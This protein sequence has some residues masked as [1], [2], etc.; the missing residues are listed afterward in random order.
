MSEGLIHE[1]PLADYFEAVGFGEAAADWGVEDSPRLENKP[2][3][4]PSFVRR[5]SSGQVRQLHT[6]DAASTRR[7]R[8]QALFSTA[9]KSRLPP[10]ETSRFLE[11]FRYVICT[12]QLLGDNVSISLYAE[13][14]TFDHHKDELDEEWI[15]ITK[16]AGSIRYWSGSGGCVFVVV[17]LFAWSLRGTGRWPDGRTRV[18]AA[19]TLSVLV[20]LYWFA[21]ARRRY[22]RMLRI[23]ALDLTSRLVQQ[24]QAFDV[25]VNKL[26]SRIQE[27]ELVSRGYRLSSPLPPIARLELHTRSRR[28]ALLRS[29]LAASIALAASAH[30]RAYAG[31]KELARPQDLYAL[32]DMFNIPDYEE[33]EAGD[34]TESVRTVDDPES[35]SALKAAFHKMHLR[36]REGLCCLLAA[37][38][39]DAEE[40][41]RWKALCEQVKILGDLMEQLNGEMRRAID[42]DERRLDIP[43]TPLLGSSGSGDRL[44]TH[45]R[46][47]SALSHTLRSVTAKMHIVR[48]DSAR[49]LQGNPEP[50]SQEELLSQYDSIGQDLR[51]LMADW[52]KGRPSLTNLF[53]KSSLQ[54]PTLE[55]ASPSGSMPGLSVSNTTETEEV[56]P[57]L[58]AKRSPRPRPDS[59]MISVG[60][61]SPLGLYTDDDDDKEKVFEAIAE[62]PR[63]KL[64]EGPR[65][66]RAERI[67][68][69]KKDREAAEIQKKDR[70]VGKNVVLELKDVLELRG[71]RRPSA[72]RGPSGLGIE[73]TNANV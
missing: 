9:L 15:H 12:S 47:I 62:D 3:F 11:R 39:G 66:T 54:S 56:A 61:P 52:E 28:C 2:S 35:L 63:Q 21:H 64:R 45:I 51:S 26:L 16:K 73:I 38:A 53:S 36:R 25:S 42:E 58:R 24:S 31:L 13:Q 22:T 20:W 19:V 10:T 37:D 29:T 67:E 14:I 5:I 7:A 55:P 33:S 1:G 60:A 17:L 59:W 44:K 70:E 18:A 8:F 57:T 34:E 4:S 49:L 32:R 69:M 6:S 48:E 27:V 46:G 50:D 68:Q 23:R 43:L 40:R 65:P 41:P 30:S 72:R 71:R